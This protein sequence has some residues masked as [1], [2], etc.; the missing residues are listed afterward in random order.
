M[1]HIPDLAPCTYF[2]RYAPALI[3]V[4]WLGRGQDYA[5]GPVPD[6]VICRL[7][8]FRAR[9]WNVLALLGPHYCDLCY[10]SVEQASRALDVSFQDG[11][12]GV[13][14]PDEANR[15]A[16]GSENLLVPSGREIFVAP[17]MILHYV[18]VHQYRPPAEFCDALMR[19]PMMGSD[20]YFAAIL[21]TRW[22]EIVRRQPLQNAD[23]D[24]TFEEEITSYKRWWA[25][26][27]RRC[28]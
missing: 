5:Q 1:T 26:H 10:E 20:A 2:G 7:V 8:E 18:R 16:K 22:A 19:C 21:Q 27:G 25:K 14:A 24:P 13:R 23:I 11:K 12:Q 9:N 3:A 17:E 15:D 4:A 28:V 6:A